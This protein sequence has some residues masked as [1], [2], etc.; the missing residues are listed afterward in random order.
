MCRFR[1]LFLD[2]VQIKCAAISSNAKVSMPGKNVK[3]IKVSHKCMLYTRFTCLCLAE[4]SCR[5]GLCES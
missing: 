3:N 1:I 4:R 2:S 5:G